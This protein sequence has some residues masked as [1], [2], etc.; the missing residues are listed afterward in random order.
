MINFKTYGYKLYLLKSEIHF[1]NIYDQRHDQFSPNNI[2]QKY[3]K[4]YSQTLAIYSKI[5]YKKGASTNTFSTLE[6]AYI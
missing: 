1:S 2:C 5:N 3:L 6:I 4:I